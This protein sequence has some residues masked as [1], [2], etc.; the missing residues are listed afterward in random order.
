MPNCDLQFEFAKATSILVSFSSNLFY[1]VFLF[2]VFVFLSL[3]EIQKNNDERF[4][5][6][7]YAKVQFKSYK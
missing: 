2:F 4:T 5:D 6:K 3:S 7:F 1:F